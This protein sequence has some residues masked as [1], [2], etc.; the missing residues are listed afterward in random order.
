MILTAGDRQKLAADPA[1]F[2]EKALKE[3]AIAS[4]ANRLPNFNNEPVIAEP[5]I[6]FADGRD[7]LF[8]EYK[9]KDII[10][11]YHLTPEE[12]MATYLER[13]Q[14]KALDKRL[15]AVS[16]IAV[17]FTPSRETRLSN[18][19]NARMASP[20][21]GRAYGTSFGLMYETL[22][23]AVSLLEA[24]GRRA[25]APACTRP[26]SIKI[27]PEG[28]PYADWSEK[29]AAY[30]AGLGTFGLNTS[31]ITEAG[32]PT[33]IGSIITDLA[34]TATPRIYDNYRAHCRGYR[35]DSCRL[36]AKHCP[37]GAV[38]IKAFDGKKCMAYT[39]DVLP[40]INRELYG[41]SKPG[42]HPMCA[43]CQIR[44]PCEAGFPRA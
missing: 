37:S 44:L 39:H 32:L 16:V 41:E 42:T 34:I 35:D 13:Q 22:N 20:R 38:N 23:Y 9:R 8:S 43:L 21:W 14:K 7:P 12:A 19:N 10:G 31:L 28:L 3:Y 1:R 29:H 15:Q 40:G 4:P 18:P 11:E 26:M 27:S 36:C 30:A 25:V 33:Q 5:I 24:A 17:A 2:L 6:G